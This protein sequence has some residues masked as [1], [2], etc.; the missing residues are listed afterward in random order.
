MWLA[1]LRMQMHKHEEF[2]LNLDILLFIEGIL[3][4]FVDAELLL[5]ALNVFSSFVAQLRA[6]NA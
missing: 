4:S 5:S 3:G 1:P 6:A 2:F